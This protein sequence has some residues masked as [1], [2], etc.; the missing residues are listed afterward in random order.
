MINRA[1]IDACDGIDGIKDGLLGDPRSCRFDPGTLL[2]KGA[3]EPTCLTAPQVTAVRSIYEGARN[4]RTGQQI[5]PG[6]ARGSEA[7]GGRGGWSAYFVG[8]REPARSDFWRSWVFD[9]PQWDPH[10]FD[11]DRDIAAADSKL[12]F[13]DAT[14]PDLKRFQAN[15]GKI[16]MY[17]R[18]FLRKPAFNTTKT[19]GG[20]WE[21]RRRPPPSSTSSWFPAWATA[22]ADPVPASSMHW[23]RSIDGSPRASRHRRSSPLIPPMAR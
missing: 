23:A 9:T 4:P 10:T 7:P 22:V 18:W 19:P 17:H 20:P 14:N 13:I 6:W 2:C 1:V 21:E 8:Q 15:Q 5:F 3:D 12:G 16:L 11:F